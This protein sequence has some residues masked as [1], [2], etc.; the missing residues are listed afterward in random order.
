MDLVKLVTHFVSN[1]VNEPDM[2]AVKQFEEYDDQ[3]IIQILVSKKD[4]GLVIGKNGSTIEAIRSL[5]RLTARHHHCPK[6][7]LEIDSF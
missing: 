4:L 7:H 3:V 5:V 1:I 6:I 2:I